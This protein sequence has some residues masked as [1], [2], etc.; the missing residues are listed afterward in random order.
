[1]LVTSTID[2]QHLATSSFTMAGRYVGRAGKLSITA[3]STVESEHL[4]ANE[5][6]KESAWFC[7]VVLDIFGINIM[8]LMNNCDNDAAIAAAQRPRGQGRMKHIP[9]KMNLVRE[10][11]RTGKIK[12][13]YV[14][15]EDQLADIFTKPLKSPAFQEMRKGLD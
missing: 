3:Q 4:S 5:T 13:E 10:H 12:M 7:Q 15:S 2:D 14:A 8:P 9:I 1:M 11:I 6:T